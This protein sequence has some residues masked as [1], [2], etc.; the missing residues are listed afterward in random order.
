MKYIHYSSSSL[1]S[2]DVKMYFIK[3]EGLG[4]FKKIQKLILFHK[5]KN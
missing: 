4:K 1:E 5:V 3:L 2:F